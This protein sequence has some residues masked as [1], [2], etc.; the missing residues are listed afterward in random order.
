MCGASGRDWKEGLNL[1]HVLALTAQAWDLFQGPQQCRRMGRGRVLS[2]IDKGGR[3]CCQCPVGCMRPQG[4]PEIQ[5]KGW[6]DPAQGMER[7]EKGGPQ[8]HCSSS[9]LRL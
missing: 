7:G 6:R 1:V 5:H 3:A 4:G 2:G 9:A 8:G